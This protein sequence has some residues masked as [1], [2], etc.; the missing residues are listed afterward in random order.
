M[1]K[2]IGLALVLGLA[3]LGAPQAR[4]DEPSLDF[5]ISP[6]PVGKTPAGQIS[7]AGGVAPLVGSNIHVDSV[8]GIGTNLN[9]GISQMI[10][11]GILNFNT[12]NYTEGGTNEWDF[13]TSGL[14][15][16]ITITGGIGGIAGLGAGSTLLS[17]QI[18]SATVVSL[19]GT[20]TFKVT[21]MMFVT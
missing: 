7:Y 12:G 10:S 21:V 3:L 9:A 20:G 19:S 17:G 5:L 15:P 13:G 14:S 2:M 16:T 18:E 1:K 4:A 8:M 6:D 11:G